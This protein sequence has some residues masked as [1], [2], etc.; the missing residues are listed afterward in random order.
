M[1]R[2]IFRISLAA[3][4]ALLAWSAVVTVGA[5][6]PQALVIQGGTLID[7]NGG[8]PLLNS[9]IVIQG[10][11]VTAAGAVTLDENSLR[12][13]GRFDIVVVN[14]E[15]LTAPKWGNGASNKAHLLVNYRY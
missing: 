2:T 13:A 4:A 15:P 9:A 10:N 11:Q 8:A 6:Q 14:P 7:G 5:Q 12:R 3:C 1:R